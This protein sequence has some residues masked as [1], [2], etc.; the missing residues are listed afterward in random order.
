M[1]LPETEKE[2]LFSMLEPH[3]KPFD[4]EDFID[5]APMNKEQIIEYLIKTVFSK[6]KNNS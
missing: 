1:T 2:I 4:I 6:K 3:I 5:E